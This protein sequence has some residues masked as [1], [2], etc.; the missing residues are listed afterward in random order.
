M[1][2]QDHSTQV[3]EELHRIELRSQLGVHTGVFL[4]RINADSELGHSGAR[5][6]DLLV[7]YSGAPVKERLDRL[8][9][10]PGQGP[11]VPCVLRRLV[12][13]QPRNV[14]VSL[15]L[16]ELRAAFPLRDVL[17]SIGQRPGDIAR[18]LLRFFQQPSLSVPNR[19]PAPP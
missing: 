9:A 1:H 8:V 7:E 17:P 10:A 14:T 11:A 19:K 18:E 16:A 12:D 5:T 6:D 13:R 15:S 3:R 2:D 4:P